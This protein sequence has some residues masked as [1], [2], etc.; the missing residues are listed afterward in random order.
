MYWAPKSAVHRGLWG[1]LAV[2]ILPPMSPALSHRARY[3]G[4]VIFFL[5]SAAHRL[6]VSPA[7]TTSTRNMAVGL[8]LGRWPRLGAA[9]AHSATVSPQGSGPCP[10]RDICSWE[11]GEPCSGDWGPHHGPLQPPRSSLPTGEPQSHRPLAENQEVTAS[12]PQEDDWSG[13]ERRQQ[14]CHNWISSG[15]L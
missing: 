14:Q 15:V 2:V 10:G 5:S 12:W 13:E 8:Q 6:P 7:P 4:A 9:L 3:R 11:G 1:L